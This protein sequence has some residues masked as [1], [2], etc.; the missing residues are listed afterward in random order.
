MHKANDIRWHKEKRVDDDVMRHPADGTAWKEFDNMYPNFAANPQNVRLGL[1]TD[2]FN[3]FDNMSKPYSMW[4]VVV[5]VPYNLP[6]CRCMKKE[7]SITTLLIL[8][9]KAHGR[10][11]NVYLRP[12]IDELKELWENGVP[13]YDK[14]INSVFNLRAALMWSINDFPAYANLLSVGK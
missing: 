7:F 12:L 14:A 2:G 9:N 3:P 11:I 13:T 10:E 1:T 5:V 8:G 4:H 6:P